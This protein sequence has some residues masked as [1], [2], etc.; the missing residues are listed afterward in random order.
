MTRENVDLEKLKREIV[1]ERLRQ[2]PP[3]INISFGSADGKFMN[4]DELI[5]EVKSGTVL[6]EKIIKIQLEYLKAFKTK[7]LVE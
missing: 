7:I 4:R 3:N 6:G 5:K 1:I 2:A